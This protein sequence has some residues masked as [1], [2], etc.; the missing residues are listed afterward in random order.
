MD[1]EGMEKSCL[2]KTKRT[3]MYYAHP[4]CSGE[5]GTNENNN[6]LIRRWIP[7]GIDMKDIKVSF[8]KKIENWINNYPREMFD[9]RSSNEILLDI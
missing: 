3:S 1:Y 4:Y 8:I 2:R 7:K 9:Y 6:R 5:R